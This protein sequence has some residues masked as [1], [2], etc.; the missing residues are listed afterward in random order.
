MR[1]VCCFVL[2]RGTPSEVIEESVATAI[3]SAECILGEPRVR[4]SAAYWLDREGSAAYWTSATRSANMWPKCWSAV[5][6]ASSARPASPCGRSLIAW[7]RK[8]RTIDLTATLRRRGQ[9]HEET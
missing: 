2:P 4:L 8:L 7:A 1:K 5:S 6:A 9:R 3:F